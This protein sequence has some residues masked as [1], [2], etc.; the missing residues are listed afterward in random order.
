MIVAKRQ[1]GLNHAKVAKFGRFSGKNGDFRMIWP[2][3]AADSH[4]LA[5]RSNGGSFFESA[6]FKQ[7]FPT[8]LFTP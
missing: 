3:F 5:G 7:Y 4:D 1:N 8:P 2:N 6:G